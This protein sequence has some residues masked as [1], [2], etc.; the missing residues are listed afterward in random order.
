SGSWTAIVN[1]GDGSG[2]QGLALMIPPSGPC[3]PPPGSAAPTASFSFD[4]LY[5]LA[6]QFTVAV[7]VTNTVSGSSASSSFPVTVSNNGQIFLSVP[8]FASTDTN[9][10][11]WGCGSFF[12]TNAT[13]GSWVGSVDYGDGSGAQP[14][15][16]NVP[17]AG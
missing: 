13:N 9:A 16:L 14:L 1:Y 11:P 12:D 3:G 7:R 6:G 2:D 4:H 10:A 5:G 8:A 15:P 17:P